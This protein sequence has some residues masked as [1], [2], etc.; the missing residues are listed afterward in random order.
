MKFYLQVTNFYRSFF[1]NFQRSF[2][3]FLVLHITAGRT[4]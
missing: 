2:A 4:V 3:Y 1:I